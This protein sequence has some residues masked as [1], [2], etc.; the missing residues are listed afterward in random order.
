MLF[1]QLVLLSLA[2]ICVPTLNPPVGL[3]EESPR[4]NRRILLSQ[5]ESGTITEEAV[6]KLIE[7]VKAIGKSRDV[8]ALLKY[9]TPFT[10]SEF[11]V[12]TDAVSEII[13]LSGI[14]EHR[15]FFQETW[16]DVKSSEDVDDDFQI[17]L[18]SDEKT[19]LVRRTRQI[20]VTL[21]D[22]TRILV[23]SKSLSRLA[24]VDGQLKIIFIQE[25]ADIDVRP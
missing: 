6:K 8:E 11:T 22:G 13:R 10:Y 2:L 4:D 19:A 3:A 18:S 25:S 1:R 14:D 5:D 24:I 15:A 17:S 16:Q 23:M 9:F 7:Q 12:N 21:K 20:N